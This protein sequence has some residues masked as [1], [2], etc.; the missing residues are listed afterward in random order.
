MLHNVNVFRRCCR[1]SGS[2]LCRNSLLNLKQPHIIRLNDCDWLAGWRI[3]RYIGYRGW[4]WLSYVG[5]VDMYPGYNLSIVDF[6]RGPGLMVDPILAFVC[7]ETVYEMMQELRLALCRESF[8][9]ACY[10]EIVG[11]IVFTR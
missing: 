11:Q 4:C 2:L 8:E 10:Q 7:P 6:E 5:R 9:D 1:F 3:R